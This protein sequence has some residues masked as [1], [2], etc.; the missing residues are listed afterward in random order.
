MKTMYVW[1]GLLLPLAACAAHHP[2][3]CTAQAE[4]QCAN[5][6]AAPRRAVARS[7]ERPGAQ[8]V[9]S[10]TSAPVIVPPHGA[11]APA[12]TVGVCDPG[13][14]WDTG[15]N[16]YNGGANGTFLNGS[17]KLCQRNGTSMQCF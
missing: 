3:K 1:I 2:G 15:G 13:G 16:R 8:S 5:P 11:T 10:A 9:T 6:A 4:A 14:C 7:P 17:G 12:P